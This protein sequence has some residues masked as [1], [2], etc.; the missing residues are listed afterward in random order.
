MSKFRK[1]KKVISPIYAIFIIGVSIIFLSY[2]FSLIG[3]EGQR[4]NIISIRQGDLQYGLEMSL[5]TVRNAFSMEGLYFLINNATS[6]FNIFSPLIMLII[7]LVG[8]GIGESSG[9]F[10]FWFKRMKKIKQP[11][12]IFITF[13]IAILLTTFGKYVF[14]I[15]MPLFALIFKHSKKSPVLGVFIA[16]IGGLAGYGTGFLLDYENLVLGDFTSISANLEIMTNYS[17]DNMGTLFIS[18]SSVIIVSIL[19][20]II[21]EKLLVPKI[22]KIECKEECEIEDDEINITKKNIVITHS[23]LLALLAGFIYSLVPNLPYSGALLDTTETRYIYMVFGENS[24]FS[25]GYIYIFAIIMVITGFAFGMLNN[26]FK[27]N[28]DFNV[29]LSS[30]F[31]DLGYLFVVVFFAIQVI[32]LFEWTNIGVVLTT[33]FIEVLYNFELSG[34]PMIFGFAI[35]VF[36]SSVL[37]T[38]TVLKW[39]L[40][41][42]LIVPLFM[43]SNV[44]PGFTQFVYRAI[45]GVSVGFTPM[46]IALIIMIGFI[47]KY[48]SDTEKTT[49][50]GTIKLLVPTLLA[51]IGLWL[52]IIV[53]WY[54][55]GLPM[56]PGTFPTI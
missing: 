37:I 14:L 16:F 23:I 40:M 51:F 32:H 36:L 19:G 17:F 22:K 31:K 41:S 25:T 34:M 53:S 4:A 15:T 11:V 12:L 13:L 28:H 26:K 47:Q 42:P 9:L 35:V 44:T 1:N 20:T 7:S 18:V 29:G 54:L 55:I 33:N 48:S 27:D 52:L 30:A 8:I 39:E 3:L 5:V 46:F 21:I 56:G 49:V 50:F 6:N 10:S 2:I 45:E 24:I 38:N 43:R